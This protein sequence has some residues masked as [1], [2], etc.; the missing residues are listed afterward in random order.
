MGEFN[1]GGT[2]EESAKIKKLNDEV[3]CHLENY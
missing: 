3:V 2:E 1:Y